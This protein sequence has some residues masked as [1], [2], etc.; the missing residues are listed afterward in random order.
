MLPVTQ[1]E[2]IEP[3]CGWAVSVYTLPSVRSWPFRLGEIVPEPLIT[4][5][6]KLVS[7]PL[8][9]AISLIGPFMVIT[10]RFS[11]P[12]IEPFPSPIQPAKLLEYG[13]IALMVTFVPASYQ[14][15]TGLT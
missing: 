6:R 2:K 1:L 7:G 12:E 8:K 14:P 3:V 4:T 13:A 9:A 10:A 15:L 5:L 11:G